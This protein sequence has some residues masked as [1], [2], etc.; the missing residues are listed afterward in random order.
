MVLLDY[1][2]LLSGI[3]AAHLDTGE[4]ISAAQARRLA[5]EAAVIPAV[6]HR[7][8]G[9]GSVV[10]DMGRKTRFHTEHQ[11]IALN[12]A[13]GGCTAEGC[14]RPAGWC[15]AHHQ[16]PWSHGGGTSVEHGRLLCPFH[17]RT[18]HNPHYETHTLPSGK[19]RFHRRT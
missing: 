9:G 6:Y 12:I 4:A 10:L 13:Q 15:H 5:C 8:L 7:V 18:A 1:D 2:K 19:L 16:I 17:H 11:R 3:G 14:D